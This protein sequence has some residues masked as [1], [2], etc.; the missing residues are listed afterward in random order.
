MVEEEDSSEYSFES[1]EETEEEEIGEIA[2]KDDRNIGTGSTHGTY[3]GT[4]ER[5]EDDNDGNEVSAR[6]VQNFIDD[7]DSS[8]VDDGEN[9]I[10][11]TSTIAHSNDNFVNQ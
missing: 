9:S 1:E 7:S 6:R 11:H 5:R 10:G 8:E 2:R 3:T 4:E